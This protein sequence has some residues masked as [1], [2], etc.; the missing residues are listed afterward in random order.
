MLEIQSFLGG[1]SW[2]G[3]FSYLMWR[4]K[5]GAKIQASLLW[6]PALPPLPANLVFNLSGAVPASCWGPDLDHGGSRLQG[7]C[8]RPDGKGDDPHVWRPHKPGETHRHG[9][10]V[11]QHVLE[12]C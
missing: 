12:C 6:G 5:E 8:S 4:R 3:L 9:A 2:L 7:A 10:H 1:L 11:A